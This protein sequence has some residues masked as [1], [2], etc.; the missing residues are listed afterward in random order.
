LGVSERHVKKLIYTGAVASVTI[1]YLRRLYIGG[2][3]AYI[4]ERR[5]VARP[6]RTG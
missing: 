4:D 1:G 3:H 6:D 5:E 2:L